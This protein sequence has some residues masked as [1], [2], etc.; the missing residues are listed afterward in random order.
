MTYTHIIGHRSMIFDEH[1][2]SLY[3]NAINKVVNPESIVLDLGA[4]LGI[5]GL[6]AIKAGARKVY[7]VEPDAELDVAARIAGQI[8][9]SD[10]IQCLQGTIEESQIPELVDVIISVFTGNFLFQE[11][12]LPSL[13]FARDKYLK[14]G[15]IMIPDCA[16]MEVVPV[17]A[18]DFF[19]KH[20][21][22]W[23]SPSQGIDFGLVREYAANN[24]YYDDHRG[25]TGGF[26]AE[27]AEIIH[28]DFIRV[29]KAD[30]RN[31]IEVKI[32]KDGLCHGW[33]GWFQTRLGDAWLSTSPLEPKTHWSQA[34]LPLDP[35]M[36]MKAGDLVYFQLHRPEFGEWTW[37]VKNGNNSQKHSTFLSQPISSAV[38]QKKSG[39]HKASLNTKGQAALHV[40]QKLNGKESTADIALEIAESWPQLFPDQEHARRFVI[41]LIGRFT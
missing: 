36:P 40:L 19:N 34:F 41:S 2:N 26:L 17:I 28:L 29:E 33:L 24:V 16:R 13:F 6:M 37:I 7:L 4:G 10:R 20:I 5:H 1:R 3:A 21:A 32:T 12:L 9:S 14:P 25:M 18:E 8:K 15:G 23:S 27:P 39:G 22:G 35:P 31:T 30:C 11:D 38:M